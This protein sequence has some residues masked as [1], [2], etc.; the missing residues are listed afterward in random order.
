MK[1]MTLYKTKLVISIIL[2]LFIAGCREKDELTLP[3][4]IYF[5]IGISPEGA[6]SSSYLSFADGHIGVQRIQF[7]GKREAGE[8]I[9]FETDPKMNLQTLEF[10]TS[11]QTLISDFDI[12]QGIFNYMKWDV[13]LKKI[14]TEGYIDDDGTGALSIGLV[15]SGIYKYS[16]GQSS[17]PVIIAID[18][19]E[20]FSVKSDDPVG[21]SRIVLSANKEYYDA[22]LLLAPVYA[23]S[24]ISRE[25]LEEADISGDPGHQVIIISR[26]E[27]EDLYENLLY[28]IALSARILIK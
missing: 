3:V 22:V 21:N 11:E 18:D 27:N 1:L 6:T 12:P 7:E 19:T 20:Q 17:I 13:N 28:R 15:I 24:S 5:K 23:F 9:F 16:D 8:D 4:R 25:S 10:S 2:I 14:V 26:N